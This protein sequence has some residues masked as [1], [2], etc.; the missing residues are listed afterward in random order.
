[1]ALRLV[2][3]TRH[4]TCRVYWLF[5]TERKVSKFSLTKTM[6]CKKE[7]HRETACREKDRWAITSQL[8]SYHDGVPSVQL[9]SIHFGQRIFAMW[10]FT[11]YQVASTTQFREL[12]ASH[13]FHKVQDIH[14]QL[15][16]LFPSR[17]RKKSTNLYQ[18]TALSLLE[19]WCY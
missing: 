3:S 13:A 16:V 12:G 1:M 5:L 17:G 10:P 7:V 8:R 15:T 9:G 14:G 11:C 19:M 18:R 2:L 6:V 4:P